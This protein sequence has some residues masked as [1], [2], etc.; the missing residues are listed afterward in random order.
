MGENRVEDKRVIE[1]N[2]MK[3]EVDMRTA[4]RI[5]SFRVGD[6]VKV[7]G[8]AYDDK[9]EIKAGIIVDF[10]MFKELPTIIVAVFNEGGWSSTPSITFDYINSESD[11]E[12]IF[13]SEEEIKLSKEGVIEKFEREIQKKKNEYTDLQSQLDYF[14]KHFLKEE[15]QVLNHAGTD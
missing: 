9:H 11:K 15:S 3:L 6:N 12:L 7:L 4:R 2:G 1:V 5:D 14:R 13:A 10:A 8:K